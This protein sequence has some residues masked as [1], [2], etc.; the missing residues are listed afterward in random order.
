MTLYWHLSMDS[1]EL[2]GKILGN[3]VIRSDSTMGIKIRRRAVAR[4][5]VRRLSTILNCVFSSL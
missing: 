1:S 5:D 4:A 2:V 3:W